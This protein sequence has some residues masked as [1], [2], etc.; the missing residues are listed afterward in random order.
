MSEEE[1]EAKDGLGED[2]E[3][4]ISDDLGININAAGAIS[5]T[6]DARAQC[7]NSSLADTKGEGSVHRVDSPQNEGETCNSRKEGSSL[8]VLALHN[9]TAV[10]A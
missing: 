7:Q 9:A 2:I 5:D 3:D 8:L 6:P 1:P 4:G 10:H